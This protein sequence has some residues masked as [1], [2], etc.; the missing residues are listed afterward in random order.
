MTTRENLMFPRPEGE[1]R[2]LLM[3]KPRGWTSFDLVRTV[4]RILSVKKAG[5]A[6]TL[7]PMASGLMIICTEKMTKEI[8]GFMMLEKEYEAEMILGARTSSYDQETPVIEQRSIDHLGTEDVR[9][10]LAEFVGNQMQV[11]PMHSAVKVGGKRLY[12]YAR[13]GKFVDRKPREVFIRS[14]TPTTFELPR[15]SFTVVCSKGTYVRS[16]VSD[17]G[18]RLGCGAYL[19]ELR[20]TRIGDYL[21]ADAMTV[22][23]LARSREAT[24]H[25]V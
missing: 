14:L 19:S 9:R 15:V 8:S 22:D 18:T 24:G 7:D 17:A 16:L 11:P 4:R 13:R 3:D 20:R 23:D 1:G 25:L 12:T 2:V 10:V 6:G 5:H 21:L